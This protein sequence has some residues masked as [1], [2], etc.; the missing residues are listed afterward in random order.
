MWLSIKTAPTVLQFKS[1]CSITE[2]KYR[3]ITGF[4]IILL[5]KNA[6]FM[7]FIFQKITLGFPNQTSPKLTS[8]EKRDRESL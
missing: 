2:K 1:P 6:S 8:F 3:E 4:I 7:L 5:Y